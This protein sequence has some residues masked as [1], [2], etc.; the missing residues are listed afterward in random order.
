MSRIVLLLLGISL[1][2]LLSLSPM[3]VG[4][5]VL[6]Y[7]TF[8][9]QKKI[10]EDLS[11]FGNDGELKAGAWTRQGKVGGALNLTG[12]GD[13]APHYLEV[14]HDDSLN[15]KD[16]V[17]LMCWISFSGPGEEQ[18]LIYKN[19]PFILEGDKKDRTFWSSYGL[20]KWRDRCECGTF[21]FD[22]NT[23][24][25]RTAVLPGDPLI[26][27]ANKWHHVVAVADGTE[28]KIY[29]DGQERA[30]GAQRGEF[31]NSEQVL[32]IGYDHRVPVE[33]IGGARRHLRGTL[34]E[35]M[36]LNVA[37][38][39]DQIQEAFNLGEK[40]KSLTD[41]PELFSVEAAGKLATQWGELKAR[42]R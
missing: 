20:V 31:R 38:T 13:Q 9:D 6:G 28:I 32:T 25:G 34:D 36:I 18:S 14:P 11:N 23:A 39:P 37:L 24:G 3:N 40:G 42:R 26:P 22:A 19:G 33:R 16:Q 12:G 4:A 10:G 27:E 35:V 21:G 2:Y 29:R 15:V 5:K 41:L 8:D 7:W 30:K 1:I 17:T